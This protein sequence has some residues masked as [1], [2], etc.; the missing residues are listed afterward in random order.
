MVKA[1]RDGGWSVGSGSRTVSAPGLALDVV[2][3][4]G[5]GDSFD[6]GYLAA[7]WPARPTRPTAAVGDDG[8][9]A[10]D[11]RAGGTGG[12]RPA[13]TSGPRD[14]LLRAEPVAGRGVPGR[15]G[16]GIQ[17]PSLVRRVAGGKALNAARAAAR[18]GAEVS[19]VV[20]LGGPIGE[21]VGRLAVADG[22]ELRTVPGGQPTRMCVSIHPE[23]GEPVEVYE[24]AVAVSPVRARRHGRRAR[25]VLDERPGWCLVSGGLPESV[26]AD[27][28]T[29]VVRAARRAGARLRWT[30]HGSALAAT[31][32]DPPDLIEVEPPEAAE[33]LGADDGAGAVDL[34]AALHEATGVTCV[35]TGR[36]RGSGR[37]RPSRRPA[38]GADNSR[39]PLPR[40]AAATRSSPGSPLRWRRRLTCRPP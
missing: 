11:P 28:M 18:L 13:T 23:D 5:A 19:A 22:L 34:A 32:G 10:L 15:P 35:V 2:D 30:T 3:T 7:L 39:R 31:L 37:R 29:R 40:W 9:V 8:R 36:D 12:R 21:L 33:V 4:T 16:T 26:G 38:C 14:H 17:R 24:P 1:G 20:L 25:R 6:A 27:A